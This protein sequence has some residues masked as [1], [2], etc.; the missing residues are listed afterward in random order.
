MSLPRELGAIEVFGAL[1]FDQD[2]EAFLLRVAVGIRDLT[3][4]GTD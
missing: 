1:D 3:A 4:R 2:G